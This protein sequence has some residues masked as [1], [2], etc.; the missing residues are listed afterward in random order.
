V[1]RDSG[2]K[3]CQKIR[4][5]EDWTA[6]A[7]PEELE[8]PDHGK[9]RRLYNECQKCRDLEQVEVR[10]FIGLPA[11]AEERRPEDAPRLRVVGG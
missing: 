9:D 6:F 3:E 8:D 11:E 4:E 5:E 1:L 2:C 7:T 10:W